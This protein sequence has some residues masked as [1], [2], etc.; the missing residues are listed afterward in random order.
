M[1]HLIKEKEAWKQLSVKIPKRG[2][3]KK[4][5]RTL[6]RGIMETNIDNEKLDEVRILTY[7]FNW[8]MKY[9][10]NHDAKVDIACSEIWKVCMKL[11]NY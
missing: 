10:T 7:I 6:S 1:H 9:L 3:K 8:A 2:L 5:L 11:G 4:H